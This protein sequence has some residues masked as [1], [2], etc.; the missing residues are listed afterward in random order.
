MTDDARLLE[1]LGDA[2]APGAA[3]PG[4]VELALLHDD[5][6]SRRSR[7][8]AP[9]SAGP[10]S[11]ARRR[12][13][14]RRFVWAGAAAAVLVGLA[15]AG[16]RTD[17]LP[18]PLRTAAFDIGLPVSSPALVATR[19]DL[20]QLGAVLGTG[21][22]ASIRAAATK[23]RGDLQNLDS[24]ERQLVERSA[25]SLLAQADDEAATAQAG[26]APGGSSGQGAPD[27]SS[28]SSAGA[29]GSDTAGGAGS[30]PAAAS[31]SDSQGSSGTAATSGSPTTTTT[32][33]T[34]TDNQDQS[35][36]SGV[37]SNVQASGAVAGSGSATTTS[38]TVAGD[39]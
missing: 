31:G 14:A 2:L 13:V 7:L 37:Q 11:S 6:A 9:A 22:P 16:V 18:G 32:T 29:A 33:T 15:A 12:P 35:S 25:T 1:L 10:G 30:D 26:G 28:S 4:P 39:G 24:D 23:V 5:L 36:A 3:E 27:S 38:T 19:G 20:S 8:T 21:R 34:T 17:R